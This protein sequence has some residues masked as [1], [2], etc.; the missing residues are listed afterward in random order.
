M[1]IP[2]IAAGAIA[3]K[4]VV[5]VGA[6]AGAAGA[7][8]GVKS[9]KDTKKAEKINDR[10]RALVDRAEDKLDSKRKKT[11]SEIESLGELK[12]KVLSSSIKNFLNHYKKVKNVNFTE[13]IAI[14][15]LGYLDFTE[16]SLTELEKASIK[17]EEVIG[18][19]LVGLGTGVLAGWG[20]YGAVGMLA[21]A[22]TGTA[23]GTLSGA[24]ASKATLAW[25]GGGAITAGGGG[26]ALGTAVLGGVVAGPALLIGGSVMSSK[27]KQ[28][29]N[30]ARNNLNEAKEIKE[31][32]ESAGKVLDDIKSRSEKFRIILNE[33]NSILKTS[34]ENLKNII[35]RNGIEWDKFSIDE[36]EFIYKSVQLALIMKD[37]IDTPILNEEGE[38]TYKSKQLL[39]SIN[40]KLH[41]IFGD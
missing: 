41:V 3:A 30:K 8:K 12:I 25:L 13:S 4:A 10:A 39:D 1:P 38:L 9:V 18:G 5:A 11:N 33:S 31:D 32:M 37:L 2:F 36:K 16:N 23:I 19:G 26:V 7:A 34:V 14:D 20:T 22:S 21:S 6:A 29:L 15:E 40:N 28:K 27:A 35:M 24:A 17:A